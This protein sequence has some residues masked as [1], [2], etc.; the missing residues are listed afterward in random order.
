MLNQIFDRSHHPIPR[1]T[2]EPAAALHRLADIA[3]SLIL[4]SA[5]PLVLLLALGLSSL[6]FFSAPN[7]IGL[8]H[9]DGIYT[10]V[11]KA[12]SEG[13]GYRIISLPG[14]PYQTKYPFLYSYL[15]SWAWSFNPQF[16][17]NISLLNFVTV[18]SYF[19]S[20]LLAYVFYIQNTGGGKA[21]ALLYV[22]LVG[23]NAS[24]F[25]M[26][27]YPLSDMPFMAACLCSLCL[28]DPANNLWDRTKVIALLSASV[29]LAFLVRQAGAALILAGLI[30]FLISR[31]R[32]EF[33]LYVGIVGCLALSWLIWQVMY[34][35]GTVANPLFAYHQ[36][37]E[38]PAVFLATSDPGAAVQIIWSNLRYL[39]SSI[40]HMILRLHIFPGLRIVIY[41]LMLWGLLSILRQQTFLFFG[42]LIFYGGLFLSWPFHPARYSMPLVPVLLLSLFH[43]V[44]AVTAIVKS[45]TTVRWS[46]TIT[47]AAVRIPIMLLALLIT[48]WLWSYVHIDRGKHLPLW[49]GFRT[50]YTW[51]GFS[52]SFSWVKQNTRTDDVLATAYD[53]MYY[54]YTG[55]KAVRPWI[56]RPET[57]FYPYGKATPDLG[58]VEEIRDT[59][60][61]LGVRFLI[62][63]PLEGYAEM[64][65]VAELFENLLRSFPVQPE[66]VFQSSDGLHRIYALPL[67]PAE[68]RSGPRQQLSFES[69]TS[70]RAYRSRASGGCTAT[71]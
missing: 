55:R 24:V 57:Y 13:D 10:V 48:G 3:Q 67:A 28:S 23:A 11:A 53:P 31:K 59:L 38:S 27:M 6:A 66:L 52:E 64:N 56:H 68:R 15:L 62:V 1:H 43:G 58:S 37:Y 46:A 34:D 39:I 7:I 54:L 40:D 69:D 44:Q 29:G 21:D 41:P 12:L 35:S 50:S 30:H 33:Y 32:R 5:W 19:A 36:S 51:T 26:T 47:P 17:D 45:R 61:S 60:E 49:G 9:D 42:F 14:E 4:R 2:S 18:F 8:F 20:L 22:F 25:S 70:F 65:A 71:V 63:E 16:P